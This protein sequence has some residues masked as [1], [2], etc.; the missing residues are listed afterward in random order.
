MLPNVEKL[1]HTTVLEPA[2][3]FLKACEAM[4]SVRNT[5]LPFPKKYKVERRVDVLFNI[6]S[7]HNR[8]K[9]TIIVFWGGLQHH[10]SFSSL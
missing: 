7:G 1:T 9:S 10:S 5:D 2:N 4:P 8:L 3:T 6:V